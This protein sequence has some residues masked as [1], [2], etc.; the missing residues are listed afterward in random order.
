MRRRL[1]LHMMNTWPAA[2]MLFLLV[3]F[4]MPVCHAEEPQI[5]LDDNP[6]CPLVYAQEHAFGYLD[7]DSCTL[8]SGDK[9]SFEISVQYYSRYEGLKAA[10]SKAKE[11][12]CRFRKNGDSGWKLQVWNDCYHDKEWESFI[13]PSDEYT[14]EQILDEKGR[15]DFRLPD[16][17][18]FKCV[19][20][21]LF[22]EPYED[23]FDDEELRRT[24]IVFPIDR[25]EWDMQHG[26]WDDENY[27]RIWSHYWEG[28]WYLDNS[29]VYVE[30]ESPSQCILR[31][32]AFNTTRFHHNDI[33]IDFISSYR[34][35]YDKEE[36]KMYAWWWPSQKWG[37]CSP[38]SHG[39]IDRRVNYIGWRA[40]HLAYG[41][42]FSEA[43]AS[44]Y[45]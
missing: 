11:Y 13:D 25:E 7:L 4:V 6:K 19:Y 1:W 14:I 32:L 23:D 33:M 22:G 44:L 27:S 36:G 21:H 16:Y 20:Q 37:Y 31:I 5:F 3:C 9:D 39:T 26:L 12:T 10:G 30:M 17:Y 43:D 45:R 40:Y 24:V 34:F 8:I 38:H 15:V 42:C 29:S 2:V 28:A 18:M 35:L 41:E